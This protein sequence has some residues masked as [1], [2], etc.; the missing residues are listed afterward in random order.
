MDRRCDWESI[1][2]LT[3]N[4]DRASDNL[5]VAEQA[6]VKKVLKVA[7]AG[8]VTLAVGLREDHSVAVVLVVVHAVASRLE[9]DLVGVEGRLVEVERLAVRIVEMGVRGD[10]VGLVATSLAEALECDLD[11]SNLGDGQE[12]RSSDCDLGLHDL[13]DGQQLLEAKSRRGTHDG[14]VIVRC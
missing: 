11:G 12:K 7:R 14:W 8:T 5:I 13:G 3:Q 6:L 2:L 10:V 9:D 1:A 4:L